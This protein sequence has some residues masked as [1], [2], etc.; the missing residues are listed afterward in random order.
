VLVIFVWIEAA[1]RLRHP[2]SVK[3]LTVMAVAVAGILINSFSAWM[4]SGGANDTDGHSHGGM[5]QRAV[6]V[7]V[8]SDLASSIGVLIAGVIAWLTGWNQADPAVSVLI[9]VLIIY[10]S[11]GLVRESVDI[12]LESGPSHMDLDQVRGGL[13]DVPGTTEVHDLHVWCLASRQ[14]A[15]SAHAVV[16]PDADHDRVLADMAEVLGRDFKIHH[17]TVQLECANRKESEP[18]HF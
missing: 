15:L 9:G 4:T 12:L 1:G 13:M 16:T 17:I 2:E 7:H 18:G 3:G 6:F 14:Y 11:W 5:A 8:L 10:G